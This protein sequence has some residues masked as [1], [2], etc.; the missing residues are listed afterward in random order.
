MYAS[1]KTSLISLV[2]HIC[3]ANPSISLTGPG[4]DLKNSVRPRWVQKHD[5]N[6]NHL[7]HLSFIVFKI[8]F[9]VHIIF[10]IGITQQEAFSIQNWYFCISRFEL[11]INSS[12]SPIVVCLQLY[13][14]SSLMTRPP[15]NLD[16]WW[17]F[18]CHDTT[19]TRKWQIVRQNDI[20][21]IMLLTEY[22]WSST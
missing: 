11:Y 19:N 22:N 9:Q 15:R 13:S 20:F 14:S 7:R 17:Y 3:V 21:V 12:Y 16:G 2:T 1:W 4:G 10:G 6:I 18:L 8:N 5:W